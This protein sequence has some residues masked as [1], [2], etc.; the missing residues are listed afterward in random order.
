MTFYSQ[1]DSRWGDVL[2]GY[3]TDASYN[4]R[5]FGCV[6]TA[7]GNMMVAVT[8]DEGYTPAMVNQ[9]MVD[10]GGF[11]PGGGVFVWQVALGMGHVTAQGQSN[12]LGAVN[13]FLASEPN[14]AI[15]EVRAGTRQHFVLAPYVDEIVDS[16]DGQVK[17]QATYPFVN[18]HLY[19]SL[20]PAPAQAPATSGALDTTV[21]VMVPLLNARPE[22]DTSQPPVAVAHYGSIHV[23]GWA[24]GQQVTVG[25]SPYTRTDNV[26]LKTD[27]GHWIAQAG[28][29]S[30]YG[31]P[32]A[33]L[34]PLQKANLYGA[35]AYGTV[36]KLGTNLFIRRKK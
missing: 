5:N 31:H 27:A 14:F 18:A 21:Q 11:L 8:G 26:W 20:D 2:L 7:Y 32:P 1:V 4:L 13:K 16:E 28:C 24:D 23:T 3:N 25:K 35:E 12:D 33:R 19:T 15:L 34:T 6:V 30:N 10:Q 9:W 36:A 17:S 22:P 29:S